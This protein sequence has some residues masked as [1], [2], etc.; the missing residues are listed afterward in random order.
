MTYAPGPA[1]A[2]RLARIASDAPHPKHTALRE[3]D[4]WFAD[5]YG[6]PLNARERDQRDAFLHLVLMNIDLT[7]AMS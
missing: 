7:A 4:A 1:D 5:L 6:W 3:V 2:V